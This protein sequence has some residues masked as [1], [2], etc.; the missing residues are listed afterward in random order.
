MSQD[1][2]M[3]HYTDLNNITGCSVILCPPQTVA[4]CHISGSSPGSRELALLAPDKKMESIHALFLTG[5]SAF[6]LNAASG[7]M[8]YLEEREIGYSTPFSLIPIVP[9]AVIYDLNIG[10][11]K[12]RLQAEHAYQACQ[13]AKSDFSDQG[14]IGAATGATVGKWA[15]LK[16]AM[17]GGLG[18]NKLTMGQAWIIAI[19]IVNSVGDI[20]DHNNQIISGAIDQNYNFLATAGNLRFHPAAEI[21]FGENT[22]LAVLL[23]N[24]K[25]TKLQA[26]LLARRAQN[27]L[28]R[29]II[30]A[31]TSYDGD[32]IFCL[33]HGEVEL[34][35]ELAMEMGSE[36]LRAS[37][38]ASARQAKS[39]GGFISAAEIEQAKQHRADK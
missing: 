4:S 35:A 5:G 12:F 13:E 37:I 34:D 15:G 17:K 30:P 6:G 16:S 32:V 24:I 33:S 10:S 7:V 20:I 8:Q 18:I 9:A 38:I 29:A 22:V 23:T 3:G 31:N 36:A 28:A 21:R 2:K 25:L 1:F 39:L 27:G 26:Y 11:S 14:S 19:S